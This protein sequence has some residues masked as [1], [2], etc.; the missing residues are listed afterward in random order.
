MWLILFWI[1]RNGFFKIK[2]YDFST[3]LRFAQNDSFRSVSIWL[4]I[5]VTEHFQLKQLNVQY[6]ISVKILY[7]HKKT[8]LLNH[9][10]PWICG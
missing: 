1:T 3:S 8:F 10:N 9:L 6:S 4:E 5:F 2:I 7:V